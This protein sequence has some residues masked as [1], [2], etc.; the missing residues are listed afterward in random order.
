MYEYIALGK[1]LKINF[2]Y[3]HLAINFPYKSSVWRLEVVGGLSANNMPFFC[4]DNYRGDH[5]HLAVMF[6]GYGIRTSCS[7]HVDEN[8]IILLFLNTN[9]PS[10]I[11]LW[12]L[13]PILPLSAAYL[14]FRHLHT[15]SSRVAKNFSKLGL[16]F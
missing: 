6:A 8:G 10:W 3:F 16:S 1:F 5:S 4:L 2:K 11:L 12:F 15:Y 13:V 14:E 7:C 9:L